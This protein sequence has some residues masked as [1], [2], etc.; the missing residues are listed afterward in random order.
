MSE[1]HSCGKSLEVG[2]WPYCP[3]GRAKMSVI[4]DTIAG[5]ARYF[6][7]LGPERVWVE[8]KSQLRAELS[9][10]GL[11]PRVQHV[12]EQGSDKSRNTTRWV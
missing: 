7:N 5:G 3:H 1:C 4:D 6:E 12:G 10:R 8:S 2:D 11:R 9:A